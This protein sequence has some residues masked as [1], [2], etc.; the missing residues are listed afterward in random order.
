M[1]LFNYVYTGVKGP[2]FVKA[3]RHPIPLKLDLQAAVSSSTWV[4]AIRYRSP[5]RGPHPLSP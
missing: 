3:R 1:I 2:V 5:A 4:L